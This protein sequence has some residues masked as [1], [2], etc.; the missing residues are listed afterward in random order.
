MESTQALN[1]QPGTGNLVNRRGFLKSL[2][3][4]VAGGMMLNWNQQIAL[5]ADFLRKRDMAL[6]VLWMAGGPSQFDTFDPKPDLRPDFKKYRGGGPNGGGVPVTQT[7]VPGIQI[8]ASWP[9]TAAIMKDVAV[10]R[11]MTHRQGDHQLGAIYGMTGY[12]ADPVI[13][14]PRLETVVAKEIGSPDNDLP[15][16]IKMGV[17]NHAIRLGPGYLG[18]QYD[19]LQLKKAGELPENVGLAGVTPQRLANRVELMKELERDYAASGHEALVR[20]HQDLYKNSKRLMLTSKLKAFDLRQEPDF[21]KTRERYGNTQFGDEVLLA[22]RLVEHGV[23]TVFVAKGGWDTHGDNT[24]SCKKLSAIVDPALAALLSDL[25]D[26][27][28]LDRTLVLWMG[29]FGRTPDYQGGSPGKEGRDHYPRAYSVAL[30]GCGIKG[31]QVIGATTPDGKE[32]KDRPVTIED[33]YCTIYKALGI[34]PRKRNQASADRSP[35][36]VRGG[37]PVNELFA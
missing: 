17:D 24:N 13:K 7:A 1:T 28:R 12:P 9:K 26:R 29:E 37:E 23:T 18:R 10:V 20:E 35:Q 33:L 21:A 5:H 36:L 22:R 34:D 11:T 16:F 14:Y 8:A 27:G 31:G 25:K 32:V 15:T 3:A 6:I 2:T 30:A 19:G 4:G